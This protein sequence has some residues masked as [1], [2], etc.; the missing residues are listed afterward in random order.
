M[1]IDEFWNFVDKSG[2]CWLWTRSLDSKGYGQ[3]WLRGRGRFRAHRIA[4]EL[5]HGSAP[6]ELDHSCRNRACVNPDHLRPATSQQNHYNTKQAHLS[7]TGYRGVSFQR[8]CSP[9]RFNARIKINGKLKHLGMFATPEAAH[10]AY[11]AAAKK[12]HG[13]F[14]CHE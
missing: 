5:T 2:S 11:M 3:G 1:T 9:P 6:R 4:Y 10:E 12:L 13:E 7:K 8:Q 14:L